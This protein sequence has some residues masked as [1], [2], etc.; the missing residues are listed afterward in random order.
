MIC[1]KC[2]IQ[3]DAI[4]KF[5]EQCY[6]G[7]ALL[8]H[9]ME[10]LHSLNELKICLSQLSC[11][12]EQTLENFVKFANNYHNQDLFGIL[13][14]ENKDISLETAELIGRMFFFE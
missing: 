5:H 11:A 12:D 9:Y 6:R 2:L 14:D 10:S 7:K 13:T 1:T 8:T 4:D 3:L